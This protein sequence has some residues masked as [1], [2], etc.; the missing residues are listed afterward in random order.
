MWATKSLLFQNNLWTATDSTF[1]FTK[2][3]YTLELTMPT[4]STKKFFNSL[5]RKTER[6]CTPHSILGFCKDTFSKAVYS[7]KLTASGNHTPP[8]AVILF[9]NMFAINSRHIRVEFPQMCLKPLTETLTEAVV[10]PYCHHISYRNLSN[11]HL[12][13]IAGFRS[14]LYSKASLNWYIWTSFEEERNFPNFL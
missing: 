9:L 7:H 5:D 14:E 8:R 4:L 2:A 3:I 6:R 10:W 11:V 12:C 13:H 1:F